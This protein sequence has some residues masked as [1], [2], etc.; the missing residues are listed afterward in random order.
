MNLEGAIKLIGESR[1]SFQCKVANYF[2]AKVWAV[3]LSPYYVD[4]STVSG[5]YH[6]PVRR[7]RR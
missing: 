6:S 5:R 4:S 2:R 3:L 1:K 7:P